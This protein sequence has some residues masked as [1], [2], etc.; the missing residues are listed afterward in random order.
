MSDLLSRIGDGSTIESRVAQSVATGAFTV[1]VSPRKLSS[2][3]LLTMHALSGLLGAVGGAVVLGEKASTPARATAALA[4]GATLY[5]LSALGTSADVRTE[6][7]LGR[8][9]V[10]H[11]RLWLGVAAAVVT[12]LSSRPAPARS[13]AAE[14]EPGPSQ[15]DQTDEADPSH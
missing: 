5:G 8:R 4:G 11:P 6:R 9:G 10:R 3:T 7:W 13:E 1:L 12:W 2:R 14:E 15:V